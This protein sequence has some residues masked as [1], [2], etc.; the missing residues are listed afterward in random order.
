[1]AGRKRNAGSN[2]QNII[3]KLKALPRSSKCQNPFD[4]LS[5]EHAA[6]WIAIKEAWADGTLRHVSIAGLNTNVTEHFG[7]QKLSAQ[8]F[9]QELLKG[10]PEEDSNG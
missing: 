7:M 1:M 5:P 9:K 6:E 8:K 2:P 4:G 3:T 10:M